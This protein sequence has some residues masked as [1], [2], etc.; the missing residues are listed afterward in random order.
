MKD[1]FKQEIGAL[2]A[3]RANPAMV[4]NLLVDSYGAKTP[5]K[6][7]AAIS[8]EDARTLRIAPW[9]ISVIKN[10]ESAISASNLG[11]QPI[12]DKQSIRISVPG[13]T[14]ERRKALVKT[15]SAKLEEARISMRQERD[16]VWKDIQEGERNGEIRKTSSSVSK[17]SFKKSWIKF[18]PIWKR[19]PKRKEQEILS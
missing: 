2:S 13:L 17:T 11:V 1:R 10:I 3:G 16:K 19:C 7:I 15:V 4:E 14:E 5:L 9:D 6:H 12:A 8:V 18:P